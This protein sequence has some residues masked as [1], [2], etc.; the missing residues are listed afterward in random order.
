MFMRN[1]I[2]AT[3][4]VVF[5]IAG[6]SGAAQTC[7]VSGI[8]FSSQGD[9]DDFSIDHPESAQILR[10]ITTEGTDINNLRALFGAT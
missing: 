4:L 6:F 1:L 8:V 5:L 10:S 3:I 9:V 2:Y 7:G